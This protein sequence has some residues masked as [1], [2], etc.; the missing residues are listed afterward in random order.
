MRKIAGGEVEID[1]R[2]KEIAL[3]LLFASVKVAVPLAE[4]VWSSRD[5]KVPLMPLPRGNGSVCLGP[6]WKVSPPS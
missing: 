4:R 1:A 3:L 6:S 5:L 2:A